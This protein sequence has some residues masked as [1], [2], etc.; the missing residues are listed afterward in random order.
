MYWATGY[1]HDRQAGLRL[2][3]PAQVVRYA[4]RARRVAGHR[5]NAAVARTRPDGDHCGCLRREPIEPL[6]C[7]H[8]LPGWRVVAEPRPVAG[9]LDL[10]VGNRPLDHQNEWLELAAIGLPPPFDD[11]GG[12]RL[13]P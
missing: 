12:A 5:V 13:G 2:P 3:R 7:R 8:G 10:L 1:A 4:H 6:T 9:R 11:R